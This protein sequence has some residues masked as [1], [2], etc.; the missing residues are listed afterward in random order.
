MQSYEI[1]TVKNNCPPLAVLPVN[2]T[3]TEKE[4]AKLRANRTEP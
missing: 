4:E 3:N 1:Q 2:E